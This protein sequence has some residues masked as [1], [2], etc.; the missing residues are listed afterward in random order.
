MPCTGFDRPNL[1]FEVHPKSV[2]GVYEDIKKHVMKKEDNG[3]CLSGSTIVYCIT[4]KNTEEVA[5]ELKGFSFLL[6][7]IIKVMNLI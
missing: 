5:F 7:C 1:Y 4:R 2:Y 6:L 3:W